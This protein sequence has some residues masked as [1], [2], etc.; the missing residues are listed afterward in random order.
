MIIL[1]ADEKDSSKQFHDPFSGGPTLHFPEKAASRSD[2]PLPDYE[3]SEAH[4]KLIVRELSTSPKCIDPRLWRAI[5]YALGI[6]VLLTIIIGV[7]II[8]LKKH[9]SY[10][11]SGNP[12]ELWGHDD[13]DNGSSPPGNTNIWNMTES[14]TKCQWDRFGRLDSPF[15]SAHAEHNLSYSGSFY[16]QSNISDVSSDTSYSVGNLTVDLNPDPSASKVFFTVDVEGDKRGLLMFATRQL[17]PVD[18]VIV[19][20]KMLLPQSAPSSSLDNFVTD[21][22]RFSHTFGD[23]RNLTIKN[24]VLSGTHFNVTAGSLKGSAISVKNSY[25]SIVGD[26]HATSSLALD[27]IKGFV[28]IAHSGSSTDIRHTVR[29]IHANITLEQLYSSKSPTSLLLDNGD[30]SIDANVS[31]VAPSKARPHSP[32]FLF[33]ANV[34]TFNGP[35]TFHADYTNS[36]PPTP[37]QLTVTNTDGNTDVTLGRKYEGMFSVQSKLGNVTVQKPFNVSSALD[38]LGKHQKY[39]YQLQ[40]PTSDH[41]KTG[42]VGWG[43]QKSGNNASQGQVKVATSLSP[44][45]LRLATP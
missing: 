37:L 3:T 9:Q 4:Q 26:F 32:P 40:Q 14:A 11:A 30:G 8:V 41:L 24:I 23:L 16:I 13:S 42:W 12:Q 25:A 7:P 27:G 39:T 15:P 10:N 17:Q 28:D 31:L 20:I 44:I 36:T 1:D 21:L 29:N 35:V 6:Y 22:P 33:T 2:S 45:M 34:Q 18:F 5:L 19:N 38:P 43:P